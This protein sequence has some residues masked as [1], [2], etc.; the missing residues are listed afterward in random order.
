METKQKKTNYEEKECPLC[1]EYL[2][3]NKE[4]FMKDEQS[5]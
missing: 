3:F 2:H 1:G 4:G 5:T